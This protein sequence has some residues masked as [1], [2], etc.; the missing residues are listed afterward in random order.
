MTM[1]ALEQQIADDLT[2]LG[3]EVNEV[4]VDHAPG[5]GLRCRWLADGP[6]ELRGQGEQAARARLLAAESAAQRR[7]RQR[8]EVDVLAALRAAVAELRGQTPD[9]N[10]ASELA[11]VLA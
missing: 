3:L 6:A 4:R 9:A 10:D 11:R 1:N 2:A 8:H 5:F 7:E